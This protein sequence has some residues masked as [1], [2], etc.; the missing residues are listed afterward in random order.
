M[1]RN[2]FVDGIRNLA[3]P[4]CEHGVDL[5]NH[6]LEG[7]LYGIKSKIEGCVNLESMRVKGDVDLRYMQVEGSLNL[8][9]MQVE[10]DAHLEKIQIRDVAE[11]RGVEVKG[12]LYLNGATF[13]GPVILYGA[14]VDTLLLEETKMLGGVKFEDFA[15]GE[16]I[17]N[18]HTKIPDDF[19]AYLWENFGD[20]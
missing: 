15:C 6:T 10:G 12:T 1:A 19:R 14:K 5:S 18:A 20:K 11:L 8:I 9:R 3:I 4:D 2:P 7:N 16:Y 13:E 17:P